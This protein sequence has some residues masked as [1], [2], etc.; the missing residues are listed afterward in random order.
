MISTTN[1][2]TGAIYTSNDV[3]ANLQQILQQAIDALNSAR[4]GMEQ[5]KVFNEINKSIDNLLQ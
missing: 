4:Q 1:Q 3:A 2:N 5:Q